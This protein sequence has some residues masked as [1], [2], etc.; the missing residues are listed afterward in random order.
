MLL[1]ISVVKVTSFSG[2]FRELYLCKSQCSCSAF[3]KVLD[4]AMQL[5]NRYDFMRTRS[6]L[7]AIAFFS[8]LLT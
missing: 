1:F 4:N 7:R 5:L 6:A 3:F 8:L 2:D